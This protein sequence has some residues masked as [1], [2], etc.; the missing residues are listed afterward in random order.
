MADAAFFCTAS[1]GFTATRA[2]TLRDGLFAAAFTFGAVFASF[3]L[4]F[5]IFALVSL[6]LAA[7]TDARV[8]L[9]ATAFPLR[10][11]AALTGLTAAFALTAGLR[12][13]VALVFGRADDVAR[14]FFWL[15]SAPRFTVLPR[16]ALDFV[17]FA[18][19]CTALDL[20]AF[21]IFLTEDIR[22]ALL[23]GSALETEHSGNGWI[24]S[25]RSQKAIIHP[26]QN[27]P[28]QASHESHP[29]AAS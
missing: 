22:G 14:G 28:A 5:A 2:D 21:A 19:A 25:N 7:P 11:A 1:T 23:F 20:G 8:A 24:E 12:L 26:R 16:A 13:S 17:V 3:G 18:L 10:G 4:A 29:P 15:A 9:A 6:A 27:G